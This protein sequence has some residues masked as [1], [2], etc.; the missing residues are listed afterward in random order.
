MISIQGT[1]PG[2]VATTRHRVAELTSGVGAAV[3]GIGI[4]VIAADYLSGVGLPILIVGL[5]LH[6]WGMTD[7]HRLEAKAGV[8]GARWVTLVYW[9][10]WALL[11]AVG[12]FVI[13]RAF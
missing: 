6:G 13:Q 8:P 10:C 9:L 5:I 4:G 7:Q 2:V 11:A 3:L 12:F 1:Q